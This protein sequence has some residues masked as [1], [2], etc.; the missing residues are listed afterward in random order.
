MATRMSPIPGPSG[1]V[2]VPLRES[3][4][5]TLYRGRKHDD[6]SPV[7]AIALSTEQPSPQSIRRLEHE[8]SFAAELD[9]AWAAKPLAITR[10]EGRTILILKDPGGEP[11]D[12]VLER[13]QRQPLDLTRFLRAAVG[14][15]K[16]LGQVHRHGLIHKDIKPANVFVDDT[17]NAWLTGFGIASQLPLER[18]SP[19]APEFIAGTLAYMAPEQTGRMNR[20]I[21]SRSDLYSLGVTLYEMLTG[22]L[23]FTASD[24]ME[25]VHCHIQ[26]TTAPSERL[27]TVPASVSAITMKLLSRRRRSGIR[28]GGS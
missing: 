27:K 17:G 20:S 14:L 25:W 10:H 12:R 23:P 1:Y 8:Y 18:Q 11:L 3:A 2:L 16:T 24:P 7:L 26:E 22:S 9:P 13:G 4:D 15:A 28:S 21:D 6:P 5:F 19:E